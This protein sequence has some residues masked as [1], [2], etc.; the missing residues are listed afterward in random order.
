MKKRKNL[1][2]LQ[3][4]LETSIQNVAEIQR[5]E[6]LKAELEIQAKTKQEK[7][8][9]ENNLKEL[10]RK[11]A[12]ILSRQDEIEELA[13]GKMGEIESF[14]AE[15]QSKTE[16]ESEL[17]GK[18]KAF[19]LVAKQEA[20]VSFENQ[21]MDIFDCVKNEEKVLYEKLKLTCEKAEEEQAKT[22]KL[23]YKV[24]ALF[25]DGKSNFERLRESESKLTKIETAEDKV[26]FLKSKIQ[27]LEAENRVLYAETENLEN[28]TPKIRAKIERADK[29]VVENEEKLAKELEEKEEALK[30]KAI[31]EVSAQLKAGDK[32]PVCASSVEKRAIFHS[33]DLS[34]FN[35]NIG[36]LR[37]QAKAL[38][39]EKQS[40]AV[41]L[42]L[43]E[44][45]IESNNNLILKNSKQKD[46]LQKEIDMI[47]IRFVDIT[48]QKEEDFL[49]LKTVVKDTISTIE[50]IFAFEEKLAERITFLQNE[51]LEIG[52]RIS[53]SIVIEE[54]LQNLLSFI[55][56]QIAECEFKIIE[57]DLKNRETSLISE[58][59]NVQIEISELHKKIEQARR[60]KE[61]FLTQKSKMELL[62]VSTENEVSELSR[63]LAGMS[64]EIE[65]LETNAQNA[66]RG[67]ESIDHKIKALVGAKESALLERDGTQEQVEKLS[68]ELSKL[69]KENEIFKILLEQT[70]K[71]FE[72]SSGELEVLFQKYQFK[73]VGNCFEFLM[74]DKEFFEL[75]KNCA[76]F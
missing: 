14:Q 72:E 12:D 41:N 73:S 16:V 42:A 53:V 27:K 40:H 70:K 35:Q 49:S 61:S 36:I 26:A 43:V 4:I 34:G 44:D 15:L 9:T 22:A 3:K 55:R 46:E 1:K 50:N 51:K 13:Q 58:L 6:K 52:T 7:I 66:A 11:R 38:Q 18:L 23:T 54:Q 76:G 30:Q 74:G 62:L 67:F 37:L 31:M 21:L 19:E 28:Q 56:K 69:E 64:A 47:F 10:S 32:C 2:S 20:L 68:E 29:L 59:E 25:A 75:E 48:S 57:A 33:V 39:L 8:G 45:K 65:S 5:L 63:K 60:E 71:N 17:K 24:N